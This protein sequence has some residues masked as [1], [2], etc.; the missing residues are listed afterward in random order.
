MA[1][2]ATPIVCRGSRYESF[3]AQTEPGKYQWYGCEPST[4]SDHT[5]R[6]GQNEPGPMTS[7]AGSGAVLARENTAAVR[8][9]KEAVLRQYLPV[10]NWPLYED[11][12]QQVFDQFVRNR[13]KNKL[14]PK[15]RPSESY[16]AVLRDPTVD[17]PKPAIT[18]MLWHA[19]QDAATRFSALFPDD[20]YRFPNSDAP[21][22]SKPGSAQRKA[23]DEAAAALGVKTDALYGANAESNKFWQ[24]ASGLLYWDHVGCPWGQS[25][26]RYDESWD[27]KGCDIR[28]NPFRIS[29]FYYVDENNVIRPR[30]RFKHYLDTFAPGWE[31]RNTAVRGIV[32][33][34]PKATAKLAVSGIDFSEA[35]RP[36]GLA[37][38]GIGLVTGLAAFS[39]VA[40]EDR[41]V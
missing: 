36:F 23:T 13:F 18:Q 21:R 6:I 34:A 7:G 9:R 40:K 28:S 39:L 11:A 19:I 27:P 25:G 37:L 31:S 8:K 33:A 17:V 26:P 3:V 41:R 24:A 22:A 35:K 38:I 30:D 14:T 10:L 2:L 29:D 32:K 5:L 12:H 20:S 15:D 16:M 1:K 4:F